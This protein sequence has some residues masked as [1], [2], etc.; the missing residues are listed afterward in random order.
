MYE[1]NDFKV[2]DQKWRLIIY[3]DG[4]KSNKG[5][6]HVSLYLAVSEADPLKV[7][8]EINATV[9][10]FVFDQIRDEYLLREGKNRRFR[11]MKHKWG[12][13][14]FL[15][16]KTFINPSNGYLVDDTCVFGVEV[17]VAKSLGLGECLTLKASPNSVCHKWKISTF[18]TSG[19][20]RCSE[21]FTAGNHNWRLHL[22]PR[23]DQ[24]NKDKNLSV[25]LCLVDSGDQKVK[26]TYTIRL[27]G[28]SGETH[29]MTGDYWFTG[30]TKK[31]GMPSSSLPLTTVQDDLA[32][33][34]F[35]VEAEVEV[36]G[37]VSKLP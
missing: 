14:R 6:D 31:C 19:N 32:G 25:Y 28:K 1:T 23:G 24:H 10:F 16:L 2:G 20:G 7:D 35:V 26:A 37:T 9:R 15:P 4:D 27:K 8:G 30:P 12:I 29:Q 36:L 13:P 33:N 17:F 34:D 3:P 21:V 22:Y 18:S 11:A 5:E